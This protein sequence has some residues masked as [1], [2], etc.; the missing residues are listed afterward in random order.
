MILVILCQLK[1]FVFTNVDTEAE[2]K[3]FEYK[4]ILHDHEGMHSELKERQTEFKER[5][6]EI[7]EKR[8]VIP[9]IAVNHEIA[10]PFHHNSI[11]DLCD[12]TLEMVTSDLMYN[13]KCPFCYRPIHYGD[14]CFN[15]YFD[16][17]SQCPCDQSNKIYYCNDCEVLVCKNCASDKH[18]KN[19]HDYNFALDT[20]RRKIQNY[21]DN[22]CKLRDS[23]P[24]DI[25]E[26]KKKQKDEIDSIRQKKATLQDKEK[27]HEDSFKRLI[28]L[29]E[30]VQN[31]KNVCSFLQNFTSIQ[32]LKSFNDDVSKRIWKFEQSFTDITK[33]IAPTNI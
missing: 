8:H 10:C 21:R 4:G 25:Q 29:D 12:T 22:L 14:E 32:Q 23:L 1:N 2:E 6:V 15:K 27:L 33:T 13:I 16:K 18:F 9:K 28:D 26:A 31:Y 11:D 3:Q 17:C 5:Q 24:S 20:L 30:E 19:H 7:E